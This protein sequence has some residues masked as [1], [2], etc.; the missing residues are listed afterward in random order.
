[1]ALKLDMSKAYDGVE[2]SFLRAMHCMG[3]ASRWIDLVM[4]C[5]STVRYK[6]V[7]GGHV[8]ICPSRGI[9]QGDPLSTYLFIICVE[10]LS[11]SIQ[12]FEANRHIQGCHVA[13]RAPS[14]THM[15]F[16][17]DNNL[18]CQATRGVAD[19]ISTLLQSFENASGPKINHSKSLIFFSP[20]TDS[21]S[22][23]QVCST[24]HMIEALEGSLYLGF[25]N[26]IGRNKNAM[27]GFIKNK[28]IACINS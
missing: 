9:H 23:V 28:V 21:S 7:H 25:P 20:N 27:L 22:R 12:K 15:F 26:I 13:H 24:L 16:A 19:S 2:W 1:M 6:V 11:A 17:D 3:F 8:F 5:V 18:F 10:G 14:I 4:T